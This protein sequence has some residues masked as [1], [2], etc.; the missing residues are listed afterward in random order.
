[1][2]LVEDSHGGYFLQLLTKS[3]GT[4][5]P[6]RKEMKRDVKGE[7]LLCFV[8]VVGYVTS[9]TTTTGTERLTEE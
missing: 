1:M 7:C 9:F 5:F 2:K 4:T 8:F 6:I 3:D